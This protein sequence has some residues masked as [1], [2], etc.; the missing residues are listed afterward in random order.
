MDYIPT[1]APTNS[2]YLIGDAILPTNGIKI[3]IIDMR[4]II[5]FDEGVWICMVLVRFQQLLFHGHGLEVNG[6]DNEYIKS[7]FVFDNNGCMVL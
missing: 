7:V 3:F 2:N 6:K 4:I 1:E 5:I